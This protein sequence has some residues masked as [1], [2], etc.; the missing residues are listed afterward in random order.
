MGTVWYNLY[1]ANSTNI[2]TSSATTTVIWNVGAIVGLAIGVFAF[3]V[4]VGLGIF[5]YKKRSAT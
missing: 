3:L 5:F 4:L 1:I 2:T